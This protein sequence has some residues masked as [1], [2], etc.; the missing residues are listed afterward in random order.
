MEEE[1]LMALATAADLQ[2]RAGRSLTD[3]EAERVDAVLEDVSAAVQIRTGQK[4]ERADYELRTRVKRGFVRLPQRPVHS[5]DAVTDRFGNA[6]S[7]TFDGIDRVYITHIP[8][9]CPPIQVVDITYDAGPDSVPDA[10]IGVVCSIALRAVG[11]DPLGTGMQQETIDGYSYTIG[12][13]AA[14]GPFGVLPSEAQI[15]DAFTRRG[16]TIQVAW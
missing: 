16:Q 3:D 1:V 4:F 12:A 8:Y 13:A 10:I 6:V 14:G 2:Y 5:V 11:V 9:G 7:H 15:L